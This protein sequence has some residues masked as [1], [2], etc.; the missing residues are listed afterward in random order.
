MMA[1][2][3]KLFKE[4]NSSEAI[5]TWEKVLEM[6]PDNARARQFLAEAR[7]KVGEPVVGA[8]RYAMDTAPAARGKKSEP[9]RS[10]LISTAAYGD[11]AP[12]PEVAVAK[13]P[14]PKFLAIAA[15]AALIAGGAVFAVLQAGGGEITDEDLDIPEVAPTETPAPSTPIE[16][17]VPPSLAPDVVAALEK[18]LGANP[19]YVSARKAFLEGRFDEAVTLYKAVAAEVPDNELLKQQIHRSLY[20]AGVA[21]LR[22]GDLARASASF[23]ETLALSGEDS[24]TKRHLAAVQRYE[25]K[26]PDDRIRWYAHLA[27]M[28]R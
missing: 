13:S 7:K 14:L 19:A 15:V 17:V 8:D 23:Q 3:A 12:L 9:A 28:R 2:A 22:A 25:G 21:A 16:D 20:N 26:A 11:E 18:E 1:R 4:G 10:E 5:Y 27:T 6:E 24:V